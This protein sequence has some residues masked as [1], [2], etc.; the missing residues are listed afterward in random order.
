MPRKESSPEQIIAKLR[1]IEVL[2][3]QGHSVAQ[4]SHEA[5][6]SEQSVDLHAG[7]TQICIFCV[8]PSGHVFLQG[9]KRIEA[10]DQINLR[11]KSGSILNAIQQ[12]M[13]PDATCRPG[14]SFR[15]SYSG[16]PG[17]AP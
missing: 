7:M 1:Q 4:A 3:N 5:G 10:H 11:C 12:A 9:F 15:V 13:A 16:L 2:T 8:S 17:H 6:I 14:E